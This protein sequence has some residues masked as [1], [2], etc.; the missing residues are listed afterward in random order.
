MR[1]AE[2]DDWIDRARQSD[3]VEAAGRFGAK[4]RRSGAEMI[5]PCPA[6]CCSTD[7][8]AINRKDKVFICRKGGAQGDVISLVQHLA[9]LDF[10][11]ACEML[12]GEP[13][14]RGNSTIRER[15]P[16]IDKER[17]EERRDA[18]ILRARE[19]AAALDQAVVEATRM[20]EGARPIDGTVVEDYLERRE[21]LRFLDSDAASDLRFIPSLPYWGF[22]DRDA[23]QETELGA[24]HCMVAAIRDVDG[25]IIGVH[26]TYIDPSGPVGLR[27]PGDRVRNKKKKI[28]RKAKGGLIRLGEIG[29]TL[30]IGEGIETTLSW[31]RM[32]K[33]GCFGEE[34][35]AA[36]TAAGVSLG[37]MA[38]SATGTVPH[39]SPPQNNPKATIAN[40]EP[41]MARPG[42]VLPGCVRR[43]IL[44][45]DGDSEPLATRA[46]LLTAARRFK[47]LGL[48]VRV[49]LAPAGKDFN[50]VVLDAASRGEL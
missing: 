22:V 26:R 37:N 36:T 50:D 39:P 4:L 29:E 12:T 33:T 48:E 6:G 38:G 9:G 8:F 28:F 34:F 2:F 10:V 35:M 23:Q 17:R 19:E 1:D 43:V 13:P 42:M 44:L 27:P 14:P 7:G 32:L 16:Q 49:C 21:V 15:D 11:G 41:D 31:R 30:A 5:G 45:G 20:F 3:I 25:R 18:D 40:G 24:F 46:I 47:A